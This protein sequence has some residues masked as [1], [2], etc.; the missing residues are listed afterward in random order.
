M[1]VAQRHQ[2]VHVAH[3][4]AAGNLMG[5][6]YPLLRG[7]TEAAKARELMMKWAAEDPSRVRDLPDHS[8]Q[9]LAVIRTYPCNLPLEA[10]NTFYADVLLWCRSS[11][12][13]QDQTSQADRHFIRLDQLAN[14]RA[15]SH[16]GRI[17]QWIHTGDPFI[18]G[19]YG[20]AVLACPT[21]SVQALEQTAEILSKHKRMGHCSE[22]PE[23]DYRTVGW[24]GE[25][26]HR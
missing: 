18:V 19:A 20:I 23:C 25:E 12:L 21:G 17:K 1:D 11:L 24:L 16:R 4:F 3:F 7:G 14:D 22:F 26:K 6:L 13:P 9:A 10:F 5:G 8:A 2:L 15:A